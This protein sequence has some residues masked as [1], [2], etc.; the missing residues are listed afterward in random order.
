[1]GAWIA[2]LVIA[3][4]LLVGALM[5]VSARDLVHTV[6]W[7]ALSLIAT[8]AAYVALHADFLA[9]AQILLYTGG[10]VTLM[11]FA[12]MLTRRQSGAQVLIDRANGGLRAALLAAA[13]LGLLVTATVRGT[14]KLVAPTFNVDSTQA[15]GVTFLTRL[16][17]PF[18]LLS[19]LLLAAM[20]GAIVL[21][22]RDG[23]GV[24]LAR[25]APRVVIGQPHDG[26][27]G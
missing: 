20:V 14:P 23:K 2:F 27:E 8:A 5:V 22:R 18:E 13:L 12:V 11:L 6:L 21:A 16:I 9:A 1:M 7:L 24:K 4:V 17:L 10:V 15:L 3:T 26:G 25:L 19:L